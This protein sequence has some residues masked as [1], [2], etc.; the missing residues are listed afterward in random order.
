MF[1]RFDF[2]PPW[3]RR[4][5]RSASILSPVGY[6]IRLDVAARMRG[7]RLSELLGP[8]SDEDFAARVGINARPRYRPPGDGTGSLMPG[9]P[10]LPVGNEAERVDPLAGLPAHDSAGELDGYLGRGGER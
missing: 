8:S 1:A 5:R 9:R 7:D 3:R 4:R 10:A 6:R 2:R